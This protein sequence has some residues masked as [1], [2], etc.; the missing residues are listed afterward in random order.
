MVKLAMA[1][2]LESDPSHHAI[3]PRFSYN[4]IHDKMQRLVQRQPGPLFSSRVKPGPMCSKTVPTGTTG[5]VPDDG[6]WFYPH[7]RHRRSDQADEAL[8]PS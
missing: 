1:W 6:Q 8:G 4:R 2:L 3:L 7:P 5:S